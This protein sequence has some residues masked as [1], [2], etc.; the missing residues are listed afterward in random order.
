MFEGLPIHFSL[1]LP[2]YA[3]EL[4]F[5]VLLVQ[6][7]VELEHF[8]AIFEFLVGPRVVLIHVIGPKG[9]LSEQKNR[10]FDVHIGHFL[11]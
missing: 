7:L 2:R 10:L 11:T 3:F 4:R 1:P 9:L 8:H 5:A 6:G